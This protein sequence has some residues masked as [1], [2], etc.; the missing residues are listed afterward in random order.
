MP[1]PPPPP[2]PK[3]KPPA[4]A[5]KPPPPPTTP[6][7]IYTLMQSLEAFKRKMALYDTSALD[8][9]FDDDGVDFIDI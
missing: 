1:P 9:K 4:T 8:A 6:P 5:P 7:K 3:T 2:R